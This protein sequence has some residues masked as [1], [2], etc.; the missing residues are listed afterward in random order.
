VRKLTLLL[1]C[2]ALLLS[3]S[4]L[5]AAE[6][7]TYTESAT[8]TGTI[9][10]FTFTDALLTIT[11]TGDTANVQDLGGFFENDAAP[12][13]VMLNIAGF[14]DAVFTGSLFVFDNQGAAAVGFAEAG[15]SIMDTFD[16]AFTTYDLTTAIG[17]ITGGSFFRSDVFFATDHG[18]LNILFAGD[19][20]FTATTGVTTPEPSA[21]CLLGIG[22]V[23]VWRRKIRN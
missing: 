12:G 20:T 3:M 6:T 22:L 5:A 17:P 13:T 4:G 18:A 2:L 14:G 10:N 21:L 8:A 1:L 9:G 23:G 7:I 16:N 11:W 15:Q 19:S